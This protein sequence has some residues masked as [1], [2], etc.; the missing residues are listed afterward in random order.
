LDIGAGEG[1]FCEAFAGL[2]E[3]DVP[4]EEGGGRALV[5]RPNTGLIGGLFRTWATRSDE[6]DSGLFNKAQ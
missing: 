4:T 6:E 1:A 2:A 5:L 3:R